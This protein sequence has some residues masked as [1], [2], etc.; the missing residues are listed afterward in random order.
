MMLLAGP[1]LVAAG[2]GLE[3]GEPG[4]AAGAGPVVT[5]RVS[6]EAMVPAYCRGHYG[7]EVSGDGVWRVGPRPDGQVLS[8]RLPAPE[9]QRLRAAA[10][11]ALRRAT[12]QPPTCAVVGPIPGAGERVTVTDHQRTVALSGIGG[13]LDASC[14]PRG[15]TEYAALFALA[16]RLMRRYYP[17]PF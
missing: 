2:V 14:S 15:G 6:C 8:G 13:R 10:E 4:L 16:D 1:V 11:R 17:H 7:F 5:V 9:A 3:S 12:D